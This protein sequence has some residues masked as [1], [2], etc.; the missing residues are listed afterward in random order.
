MHLGQIIRN[1]PASDIASDCWDAVRQA[2]LPLL[3][4][5]ALAM[6]RGPA[7]K[8]R[9]QRA[10]TA[11]TACRKVIGGSQPAPMQ[12]STA[13]AMRALVMLIVLI[14]V[15]LFAIFGKSLPDVVKGLLEGRGLVLGPAPCGDTNSPA[16][17]SMP[18][19]N[20][21]F[22]QAGPYR[23][24]PETSNPPGLVAASGIASTNS[25]SALNGNVNPLAGA[26]GATLNTGSNNIAGS[27]TT[28]PLLVAPAG[29]M[30][31]IGQAASVPPTIDPNHVASSAG[32][33]PL[34]G[35]SLA[36]SGARAAPAF[37]SGAQP[38]SFMA[39]PD[40]T[41][42]APSDSIGR[43]MTGMPTSA[44]AESPYAAKSNPVRDNA[45]PVAAGTNDE[46]FRRAEMRLRE[47][48]ATHYMLET[49]GPDNN[50]YRFVCKMA[51]GGNAEVN[52]Y[53]QAIDENPWQA[54]ETVL[55]QVEDWR[56][57]GQ[58]Q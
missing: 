56:S 37:S 45:A 51:I 55:R 46:K 50:R 15:P 49:W 11:R 12:S 41:T 29:N 36:T 25:I 14:S 54:M 1:G 44:A 19:A 38:A 18:P 30:A 31:V 33:P 57:R 9:I 6:I 21:P 40:A 27:A 58:P 13:I 28:N 10:M 35:T 47:L 4:M 2:D 34:V 22:G 20:N 3:G 8:P 39:A 52:R 53:F 7:G 32:S 43:D 42:L 5:V 24:A 48:G 26:S 16:T 17:S 23:A